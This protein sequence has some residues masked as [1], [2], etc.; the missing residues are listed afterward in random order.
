VNH[1]V[2]VEIRDGEFLLRLRA[3]SA[4]IRG[5]LVHLA[6]VAGDLPPSVEQPAPNVTVPLARIVMLAGPVEAR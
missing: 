2:T 3:A 5:E 1:P 4:T 6:N